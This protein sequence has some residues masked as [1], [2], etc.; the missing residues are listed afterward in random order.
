MLTYMYTRIYEF[1]LD[2]A[3]KFMLCALWTINSFG[4]EVDFLALSY[5]GT[6]KWL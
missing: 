2:M 1:Y 6:L 3:I 4:L 5:L